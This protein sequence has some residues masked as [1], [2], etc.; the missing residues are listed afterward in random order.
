MSRMRTAP[1]SRKAPT[2]ADLI[3]IDALTGEEVA[4]EYIGEMEATVLLM[5]EDVDT[6]QPI[7]VGMRMAF[8]KPD[9]TATTHLMLSPEELHALIRMRKET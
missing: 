5:D 3:R 9:D 4:L 7:V 1:S 2:V 8:R 6:G